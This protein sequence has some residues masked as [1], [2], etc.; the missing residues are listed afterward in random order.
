MHPAHPVHHVHPVHLVLVGLP[1]SGKST[2]GRAVAERLGRPFMDFDRE[3]ERR[4]GATVAQLFAD[5]GEPWFR[6]QERALTNELAQ[7]LGMVLA[8]G[9]GWMANPGCYE[10]IKNCAVVVYLRVTPE[11]ALSRM[12]A[13]RGTRPLLSRAD[14]LAE[15]HNLKTARES[16]YLQ[17]NHTVSTE[18]MSLVEVVDTIVVLAGG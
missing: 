6:D 11:T 3:I 15:L 5:R 13:E 1:G 10:A 12:G 16:A 2:V 9:G 4:E 14:P 7:K 17:A 8:P 18:L